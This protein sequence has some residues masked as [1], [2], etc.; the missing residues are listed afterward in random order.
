L[1][2]L[3]V[4][5]VSVIVTNTLNDGAGS[6]RQAIASAASGD[7]IVFHPDLSGQ[8]ITLTTELAIAKR[9]TLDGSALPVTITLSGNHA[10]RILFISSGAHVTLNRLQFSAGAVNA[11]NEGGGL[12]MAYGAVVTLTHSAVLSCTAGWGGGIANGGGALTVQGSTFT[13]NSADSGGGIYSLAG[14]ALTVQDSTFTGN[15]VTGSG[16]G[17]ASEESTLTVQDSTFYGNQAWGG[18]GLYSFMDTRT[19]QN[20]TFVANAARR[21]GGL[22]SVGNPLTLQNCTV[23]G[24]GASDVGGGLYGDLILHNTIVWG[25][26]AHSGDPQMNTSG[27][28][29]YDSVVQGGCPNN[30]ACVNVLSSDPRLGAL[31]DYG[32]RTPTMPLLTDSAALDAGNDA[33]CLLTDQ[34]GVTRP[35]RRHCDI[36][37][38]EVA[39]MIIAV[40]DDYTAET[41]GWNIYA[42]S[43]LQAGLDAVAGGG[44]VTVNAGVYSESA[45]L[46]KTVM[47]TLTGDVVITGSLTLL[48][49][50]FN[51]QTNTLTLGGDLTSN[52]DVLAV[53]AG[54]LMLVGSAPQ[55]LDSVGTLTLL[56]LTIAN[57]SGLTPAVK[58]K[59]DAVV[60][61]TLTL[62]SG[63][64]GVYAE[65]FTLNGPVN[66]TDGSMARELATTV[67]AQA[68]P[69]QT[70][71]PGQYGHLA[72]NDQPKTLPDDG[73]VA[74]R[75]N[76]DPGA[77]GGH[78]VAGST[79]AFDGAGVQTIANPVTLHNV[80]V[81]DN[82]TL[83][84]AAVVAVNGTLSNAGWTREVRPVM[85]AGAL[86]FGL[87]GLTVDVGT[88]GGLARLD[89][90]RRDRNHPQATGNASSGTATGR[91]WAITPVTT[92]AAAFS[93]TLALPHTLGASHAQAQVCRY[94]GPAAPGAHWDC[95]RTGSDAARV[96]RASIA[97][98]SEWAA[99]ANVGP[100]AVGVRGATALGGALPLW[101]GAAILALSVAAL[102]H[103]AQE[104]RL[105]R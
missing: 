41:V 74:I 58:L 57:T 15:S 54:A 4:L 72:F 3:R 78:T 99:G 37:A 73:V 8:T 47:V 65:T 48:Q 89:V 49:G 21:G 5:S 44:S 23:A 81:G 63:A 26:T 100:T 11:Y 86:A 68:A 33:T 95:A 66:Y 9:L 88:P 70:V 97:H 96:W 29:L 19:V 27:S 55:T 25:N 69:G 79:V 35:R 22:Y 36:G 62:Q 102:F 82:V 71:A 16:G 61:G 53:D 64:L 103:K 98:F 104:R 45:T 77:G 24:N 85:G 2:F 14:G 59:T 30:A 50:A 75:G 83:T 18:G 12:Y 52:R 51:V 91:Y 87:A 94:A 6:L 93:V 90:V 76:F 7:T 101:G 31:G 20:N 10:T 42:F 13:G 34:R 105:W 28:T 43:S 38:F 17:L 46:T 32:G 1:V 84:T 40:D 39:D 60:S 80:A 56:H 67:Y 92:T